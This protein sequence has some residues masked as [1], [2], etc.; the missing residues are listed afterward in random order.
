MT[1]LDR[2][3]SSHTIRF[4]PRSYDTTGSTTYRVIIKN[5]TNNTETYN[6]TTTNFALVDYYREY[7]ASF[8][9]DTTKDMTYILTITDTATS[10][11][12]YKEKLFV[13][14]QSASSYSVNT[15]QFTFETSSTN[16]YLVYE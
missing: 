2:D 6:G 10:K 4:V 12:I 11:V 8:G 14:D 13:T 9:F 15:G 7:T 16:D 3:L 1:I 5:E